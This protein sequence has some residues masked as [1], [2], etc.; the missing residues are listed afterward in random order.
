MNEYIENLVDDI[1]TEIITYRRWFHQNPELSEMEFKTKKKIIEFLEENNIEYK[2]VLETGIHAYIKNKEG[3][4]LAYRA[5]MDALPIKEENN[6]EYISKNEGIM[7]ACGHDVHL[8][9]QLGLIK[10]LSKSKNMWHGTV[11][12]FFQPAEETIGGAK[13]MLDKGVNLD[14]NN[15][16]FSFHSAPEIKAGKIGIKFG[17]MHAT[18]SVFKLEILGK[19]VHAALP[20][21]GIDTISISAKVID[22][23]SYIVS[24]RLDAR[25][26]AVITVGTINGGTAEN[27]VSDKVELTGTIRALD[28]ETKEF[29][30]SIFNNELKKLVESYGA[31]LKISI[32]DSYVP[33]INNKEYT[34][35]LKRNAIDILGKENVIE[36]E[37]TRMDVEDFGYFLEEIPGSFYRLGVSNEQNIAELHTKDLVIDEKAIEIGLKLNIKLALEYLKW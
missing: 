24:R 29:I 35:F 28:K 4:K 37:E 14:K 16:I 31:N 33:V 36:I 21:K 6:L 5:D 32:R 17:K 15:A 3:L 9:V 12:F 8:A 34:E 26:S 20:Y 23:L 13:R 27:V 30:I 19:Q 25:N 2:E 11:N 1:K 7:H 18:S 10:A 22:Y